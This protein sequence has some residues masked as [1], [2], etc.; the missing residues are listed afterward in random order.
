[1]KCHH[2]CAGAAWTKVQGGIITLD[3]DFYRQSGGIFKAGP[4]YR[5]EQMLE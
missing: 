5:A 3:E 2:P 1:M 4:K